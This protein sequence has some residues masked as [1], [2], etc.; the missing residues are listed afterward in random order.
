MTVGQFQK[1][2]DTNKKQNSNSKQKQQ[3]TNNVVTVTYQRPPKTLNTFQHKPDP[4]RVVVNDA[5]AKIAL[6]KVPLPSKKST[7]V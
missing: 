3:D 1:D 2:N 6:P 7:Y 5:A 4:T